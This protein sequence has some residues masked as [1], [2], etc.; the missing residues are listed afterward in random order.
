MNLPGFT[1]EV[2][3]LPPVPQGCTKKVVDPNLVSGSVSGHDYWSKQ[4]AED[5]CK[6]QALR[7]C[8]ASVSCGRTCGALGCVPTVV[9]DYQNWVTGGY[10][11]NYSSLMH[12]D[13]DC[14]CYNST[15][16]SGGLQ[17]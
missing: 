16:V 9:P 8:E 7:R 17:R 12:Y 6:Q 13:C 11:L 15:L 2:P 4:G 10:W 3:A 5:D 1:A 14:Q